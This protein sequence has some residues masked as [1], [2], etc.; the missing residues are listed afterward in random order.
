[1]FCVDEML[2]RKLTLPNS[3]ENIFEIIFGTALWN[4][5]EE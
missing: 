4:S 2:I 5:D 3:F 1:M